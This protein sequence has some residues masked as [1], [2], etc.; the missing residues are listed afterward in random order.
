MS[1]RLL[2]PWQ[3]DDVGDTQY[4]CENMYQCFFFTTNAGLRSGGGIGDAVTPPA[5]ATQEALYFARLVFDLSFFAIV[6]VILLNGG[7]YLRTRSH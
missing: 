7:L 4:A 5:I 2:R 6:V 1:V 3:S